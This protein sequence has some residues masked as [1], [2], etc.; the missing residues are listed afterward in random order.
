[1]TEKYYSYSYKCPLFNTSFSSKKPHLFKVNV[2][3]VEVILK[4]TAHIF[5][6]FHFLVEIPIQ[7]FLKYFIIFSELIISC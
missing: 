2:L 5:S 4:L 3:E 7:D 1:M 6:E